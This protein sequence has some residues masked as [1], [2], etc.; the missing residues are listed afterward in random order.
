MPRTINVKEIE[1]ALLKLIKAASFA[2]PPDVVQALRKA[3]SQESSPGGKKIIK[4]I[5]INAEVAK[6][7]EVPLCQDTGLA[8]VFLEVGQDV[9]IT[10]GDL[11]KALQRTVAKAYKD[12]YLRRSVVADPFRRKN[13]GDNTPA[14]VQTTIVPGNKLKLTF[15][16]KGAGSEN[17]SALKMF[18]PTA[19]PAELIEFV[20]ATV[21]SAQAN[22]CP[23]VS[24][25]LGLGGNFEKAALLAKKALLRPLTR[26]HP[27]PFYRKLEK[28]ILDKVN[29]TGIGPM[30]LGG[31]VTALAVHIEAAPC[32]IASLP[33][34]I[35]IQCHADRRS[36]AVL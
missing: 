24:I 12:N 29:R 26:P 35:N 32:H 5:L 7:E 31:K 20:L 19:S 27:Q 6:K 18:K 22:P 17:C 9:H 2:L 3:L 36:T 8:L 13:T 28:E 14:I 1:K 33:A 23:P 30:G 15:L 34:A 11:H 4:E 25:G 16:A 10:G 21:R